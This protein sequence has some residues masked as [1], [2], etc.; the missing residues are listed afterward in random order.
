[1]V[2]RIAA[3]LL[4]SYLLI[5]APGTF[6][7]ELLTAL[8]S[9]GMRGLPAWVELVVHGLVAIVCA[10]AGRMLRVGTPAASALAASGVL[11]RAAIAIQSLFW[12]TLPQDVAPG[13]RGFLAALACI[14][15]L[16][17]LGVLY[18]SR[19]SRRVAGGG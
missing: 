19:D 8:P 7:V 2:R 15:A 17:W 5:W 12:T 10:V 13:T 9:M 3:Q 6:A 1:V 16:V 18:W 14:N 4:S 11:A